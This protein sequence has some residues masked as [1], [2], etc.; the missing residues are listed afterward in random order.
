MSTEQVPFFVGVIVVE[1]FRSMFWDESHHIA[2]VFPRLE[3]KVA[4]LIV[5]RIPRHVNLTVRLRLFK[6]R[7]PDTRSVAVHAD[8]VGQ[9]R[10][11]SRNLLLCTAINSNGNECQKRFF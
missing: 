6:Q 4:A 2:V 1:V 7:P 10:L 8:K 9:S 5:K 11:S 3:D